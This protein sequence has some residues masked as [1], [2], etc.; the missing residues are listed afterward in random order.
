MKKTLTFC[1]LLFAFCIFCAFGAVS[2]SAEAAADLT[3][4]ITAANGSPTSVTLKDA[5]SDGYYDIGTVDELYAFAA[6][7]NGG[8][9]AI[10]GELTANITVNQ[11]VLVD[12]ALNSNTEGFKVW[13]PIGI[14]G[15]EYEGIFDG[16]GKTI[17]GLYYNDSSASYVGLFGSVYSDG[18][19]K[20]VT[21]TDSSIT[22]NEYVGGIAGYNRGTVTGCVNN[23]VVSGDSYFVGGIAGVNTGTVQLCG[24]TGKIT[25][26]DESGGIAG[27]STATIRSCYNT[28]D[29]HAGDGSAGGVA[30]FNTGGGTV[31]CCWSTGNV[32]AGGSD[33]GGIVGKNSGTIRYCYA[34]QYVGSD[35]YSGTSDNVGTYTTEQFAS[36]EVA[37]LLNGSTSEGELIWKQTL[38]ENGDA[39]PVFIG[40]TVYQVIDC[41]NET[42]YSNENENPGHDYVN[43]FCDVCEGYEPATEKGVGVNGQPL[44][45]ISNAGQLFWFAALVNGDTAA[46][47]GIV[48][49]QYANAI[50]T[51]NIDLN[52]G[53]TFTFIPDTGLVEIKRDGVAIAYLGTGKKGD[54]SGENIVFDDSPSTGGTIYANADDTV[55]DPIVLSDIRAWSPM[56]SDLYAGSFDG[57]GKSVGGLYINSSGD[58]QGLFAYNK[59]TIKN[60][61]VVNSYVKGISYVG[62]M[63]AHNNGDV[64]NSYHAGTVVGNNSSNYAG[65]VVGSNSGNV[66]NSYNTGIVS[67]IF[68]VGGVVGANDGDVTDSY[69]SGAVSIQERGNSVGGV[70]G[71][72][73]GNVE[74]SHNVGA[75]SG[76]DY[77][78]SIGGVVGSNDGN[79]EN[80][81]N[82]GAVSG[83]SGSFVGGVVGNNRGDVE[84]SYN[85]G[86]VSGGYSSDSIGGVVGKNYGD[87]VNSHNAGVVSVGDNSSYVGGVAGESYGDVVNSHNAG[88]V[89]VGDSCSSIGGVVGYN[90]GDIVDSYN[91]GAVSG[92]DSSNS[93]GGVVGYSSF[94][95]V[96]NS[97]NAGAV[98]VGD[99]SS[100]VGGVIGH[101]SDGNVRNVYNT[102]AVNVG[103][104]G[105]SVGGV[106]GYNYGDVRNAYN[107]G[108]VSSGNNSENVGGVVGD[109]YAFGSWLIANA[110]YL[111]GTAEHGIGNDPENTFLATA[112]AEVEFK[113]GTVAWLLN[114]YID[115]DVFGQTLAG[116]QADASPVF[117]TDSN[118]IYFGYTTCDAAQTA[119]VYSNIST[120]AAQKPTHSMAAATCTAPSACTVCGHTEGEALGHDLADATCTAPKTC[121][122]GC[123]YT[124]GEI[125]GHKYDN[126]C[127][128]ACNT[129]GAERTVGDH[130]DADGNGYCDV[131]NAEI[132]KDGLSG[133][134]VA[135]IVTGSVMAIGLGGFALLWFVIKKKKWSDLV[136]VFKK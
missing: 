79:V 41:K 104:D 39:I 76:G 131:C 105:S 91:A 122:R 49:N 127:D 73:Y 136:G 108:T 30:G 38:G 65:G 57:N 67:G 83:G 85:A 12:G 31:E 37:Y 119:P 77:S 48:Q 26:D 45:E 100:Y 56:G 1:T 70:V 59:G 74:N 16:N 60:V 18:Q 42:V 50:L 19:M 80:S 96:K 40:G 13:T 92:G 17:S 121:K 51:A 62:G 33:K 44:Y 132:P 134:A 34:T 9:T 55:E 28:G 110:Y 95:N 75:V 124:E 29:V 58:T 4:E 22:G 68:C 69:N 97:Y 87:I 103:N 99:Y 106:A 84:N 133:G 98:S 15:N 63:V 125:L 24:N 82:A 86:T 61:G 94:A 52:P 102:G 112:K 93:V 35:G 90:Y 7:V 118:R 53:Y 25:G 88:V 72:N 43:G 81:H 135:G 111:V 2:A 36:G 27:R 6:A 120:A 116:A 128:T 10:N 101:N 123:G 46:V 5:D 14:E 54:D 23:A 117:L 113:N 114:G 66:A 109:H 3:V 126:A 20:A 64:I 130:A 32:T 89:S 21:L 71:N 8:N 115:Y 107:T 11:N 78:D 47:A 129:C